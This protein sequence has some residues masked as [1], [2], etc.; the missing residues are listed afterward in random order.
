M[1]GWGTVIIVHRMPGA[2]E[3]FTFYGDHALIN[4]HTN[5]V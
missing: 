5:K 2:A 1:E 3:G 4:V